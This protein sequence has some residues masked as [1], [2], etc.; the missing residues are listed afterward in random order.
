MCIWEV[1]LLSEGDSIFWQLV[2]Q[3]ILILINAIFACAEIAVI[4]MNDTKLSKLA[5]KGNKRAKRLVKLTEQPSRFLATIQVGITFAGFL[6]SA[7]AADNFSDKLVNW[8]VGMGVEVSVKTLDT[9]SV[10]VITLILS[11]FTL[12][13]G[14]LVPKRI[15]MK[16]ADELALAISGLV[17]FISKIFA[18]LVSLLTASTNGIL[19]LLGIDPNAEDD[20]VTE[21]EI[22]MMVQAG[23]EKGTIDQD[24][25]EMI[26]NVFEFDDKTAGD[27]MTHRTEVSLLWLEESDEQWEKTITESRHTMYPVCDGSTDNIIGVLNT[28]DY[29]RIKEK[30]RDIIL[31]KA[32]KPAYFV[33]DTV[34]TDVLFRNMKKSRHRFAIVLDEYGGMDGIVTM[35]DILEQLVGDLEYD[36]S[37][38]EKRPT[39]ERVDSHTWK[40]LGSPP[41]ETVSECLGIALPLDDYD[42]FGGLVFGL[43]G[44]IPE[45]GSTP[46]IEEYGLLIKVLEIKEHQ[47]EK[48]IIYLQQKPEDDDTKE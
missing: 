34:R 13:L 5:S 30:N 48:A 24:E 21:E 17:Y 26:Q 29:F 8:L 4:S 6:G 28:K 11:Y 25:K 35:S 36:D 41:L 39:I 12:V 46:E 2:L 7:F 16:K 37:V 20:R 43:L 31:K 42:T 19:K 14:E 45:D 18:P 1:I 27:I 33:P 3:L 23:S 9:I 38:P 44:Y 15:A 32:V 10:I 47:L 40:V 22:R